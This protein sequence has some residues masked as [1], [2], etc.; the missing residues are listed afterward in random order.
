MHIAILGGGGVGVCAALEIAR[1]GCTVDIYEQDPAPI[2]RAS[3]VNEGK[4]HQGFL[5]AKDS[6]RR[7]A[8]LLARGALSFAACLARW[9]DV[10]PEDLGL[11]TPFVYAVHR[12]TML[13]VD[14]L[15]S[16]YAACCA[17]FNDM[18]D[19][20]DLRYLGLDEPAGYRELTRHDIGRELDPEHFAAAFITSER[21]VDPRLV[22][23]HLRRALR[24]EPRINFVGGARVTGIERSGNRHYRVVFDAGGIQRTGPYDHVVN[25]LWESRLA[26]DRSLQI[27]PAR[28]W[29][30]RH[31]FG[32]RVRLQL[33]PGDLPS[34]T[35][36]LGP[37]GDIVNFG[38]RG[39]YL[40]WYPVGMVDV[41][42]ESEPPPHWAQ[43]AASARHDV[44]DR[45]LNAWSRFCPKLQALDFSRDRIDADSGVIFAWG[46]TDIDDPHSGLHDRYEIGIHSVGGY[47]SVNT[48]KYTMVPYLGLKT[49]ERVLGLEG[50]S[51]CLAAD[52]DAML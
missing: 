41:S 22:A 52:R 29:L 46:A 37:F 4:I 16:H 30:Y 48:G 23:E 24:A 20:S 31:K 19:A 50:T 51:S 5:Y 8:R 3:R 27:A 7:T 9:V 39:F 11:S 38:P 14:S 47:H 21:A 45:S 6:S 12:D 43:F 26:I 15:R 49:A 35:M 13:D 33:A 40:S 42:T 1:H 32:N 25:A 28:D 10:T 17:I 36:V 44:F 18:R 34:V 2:G